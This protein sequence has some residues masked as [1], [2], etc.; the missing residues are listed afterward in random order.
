MFINFTKVKYILI[1]IFGNYFFEL[2]K[3]FILKSPLIKFYGLNNLDK[4]MLNYVNYENGFYIEIG[5][6]DG[7]VQS[8]T[9]YFEKKK[10]WRGVLIE[11]SKK[12]K[13]LKK[14][15]SSK[16]FFYNYACVP[17]NFN[18][19]KI[20]LTYNNLMTVSD[21]LVENDFKK[22]H[23]NRGLKYIKKKNQI[24]F[25]AKCKTLNQ[26]LNESKS[27]KIID[28]FSLDVEGAELSVLKGID[29]KKYF[30]KYILIETNNFSII[31][32]FLSKKKY[33][34][35]KKISHHDYLF[36]YNF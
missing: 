28:F 18:K 6:G 26:I 33:K 7:L 20:I 10:N 31:D 35:I 1:F 21:E 19:K 4:K 27:P 9:F 36:K 25:F 14:N 11:P 16:N 23:L 8:N 2:I 5:A 32:M 13:Y 24:R 17:F 3:R 29:F 15:R 22:K 30:F 12:F 34:F